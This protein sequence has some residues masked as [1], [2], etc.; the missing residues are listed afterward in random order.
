MPWPIVS[1]TIKLISLKFAKGAAFGITRYIK[2][3]FSTS[4]QHEDGRPKTG[5][6]KINHVLTKESLARENVIF[7]LLMLG[8]FFYGLQE[9][10]LWT[11]DLIARRL[12]DQ[13]PMG[14]P[15]ALQDPTELCQQ[16]KDKPWPEILRA[17]TRWMFIAS[18]VH[19]PRMNPD[20]LFIG[21]TRNPRWVEVRYGKHVYL[22]RTDKQRRLQY[23]NMHIDA[24]GQGNMSITAPVG[25][26][27]LTQFVRAL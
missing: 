23:R 11:W 20:G 19:W 2:K 27:A 7:L 5:V 4:P 3:I 17:L 21:R 18:L 14:M 24:D 15:A 22:I 16:L 6:D 26:R 12:Y 8:N 13:F 25:E 9:L 10:V 1:L